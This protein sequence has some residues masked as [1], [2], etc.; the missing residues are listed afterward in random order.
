MTNEDLK[1]LKNF[2]KTF[3]PDSLPN[4][5]RQS[6]LYVT[7]TEAGVPQPSIASKFKS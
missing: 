5:V 3:E 1:K 4:E 6:G 7:G 2:K